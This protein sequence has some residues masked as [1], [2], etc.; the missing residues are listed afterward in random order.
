[1]RILA[2]FC[3]VLAFHFTDAQTPPL[4]AITTQI[5]NASTPEDSEVTLTLVERF[6][7]YKGNTGNENDHFDRNINS[8][9]SAKFSPD[10]RKLYVQSLE[11]YETVVYDADS[12]KKIK[13]IRH[14]FG[15]EDASLFQDT[16]V[17]DYKYRYRRSDYN[18]FSGKPVENP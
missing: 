12:L 1:M 5:G 6:Q 4:K 17:F 8:P 13:V 16:S 10:G 15:A 2:L 7:H 14:K 18:I 3:F 9:K 11:G